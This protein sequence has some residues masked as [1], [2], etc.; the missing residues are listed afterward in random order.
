[1]EDAC[2]VGAEGNHSAVGRL[3]ELFVGEA[4][5]FLPGLFVGHLG[6]PGGKVGQPIGE[7]V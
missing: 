2:Q 1:M 4:V 5:D 6:E 7:Y 3:G